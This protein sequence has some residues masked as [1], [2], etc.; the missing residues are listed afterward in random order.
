M[1]CP[2]L[3]GKVVYSL[4]DSCTVVHK[5]E[6]IRG[7]GVIGAIEVIRAIKVIEAI[8]VIWVIWVIEVIEAI[9][10]IRLG[11]QPCMSMHERADI[12]VSG[13]SVG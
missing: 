2:Y 10:Q 7:G 13:D 12:G 11:A 6:N 3:I 4:P 9:W 8:E 5:T 1:A